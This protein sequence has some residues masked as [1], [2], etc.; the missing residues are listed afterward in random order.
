MNQRE[1]AEKQMD[2]MQ[3]AGK[4]FGAVPATFE[5]VESLYCTLIEKLD[6]HF[7]QYPYLL[8]GKPSIG[9][10]G[11]MAPLFAHLGRGSEIDSLNADQSYSTLPLGRTHEPTRAGHWGV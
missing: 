7:A 4:S 8:G 11:L 5:L 1:M 3:N 9:D 6:K 2:R 10:F